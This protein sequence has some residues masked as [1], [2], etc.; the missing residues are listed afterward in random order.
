MSEH[1]ANLVWARQ[2]LDFGYKHY[3]RNHAWT[4][5]NGATL[6]ASA[7][8]QYLGDPNCVDPEQAFVAS[9]SSCHLL[10]FLALASFQKLT[11]ERYEDNAVGRMA[12]NEAGRMVVTRVD[13][14]PQI[15]FAEGIAPSREQLEQLH[16]KA[17]E[18]CFLANSVTC[19]IVTHI[20]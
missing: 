5:E 14:F 3:S 19:E 10:T 11:V 18:E 13:L 6:E 4:F 16:R 1:K 7:A 9:L 20:E 8:I 17:H 2:G 12:K 15:A